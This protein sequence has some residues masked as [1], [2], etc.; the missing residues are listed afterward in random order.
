MLKTIHGR[1][2]SLSE[3]SSHGYLWGN[4]LIDP[5]SFA[6][7]EALSSVEP[8]AI[9]ATHEHWDHVAGA[10]FFPDVP[11]YAHPEALEA[12]NTPISAV[13][14]PT[15][16]GDE[17]ISQFEAIP[18]NLGLEVVWTPG[19]TR[20]SMCLYEPV[21]QILFVGDTVFA[22]GGVGRIFYTGSRDDYL[23]SLTNL[24]DF[25]EKRGVAMICSGHGAL[26]EGEAVCLSSLRASLAA[27]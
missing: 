8:L 27:L 2:D 5:G 24:V 9:I 20:G 14:R 22:D 10:D 16:H 17:F 7:Q 13:V 11:K 4:I 19:H 25:A 6:H 18:E 1:D 23:K 12:L 15:G 21:E 3:F 26:I